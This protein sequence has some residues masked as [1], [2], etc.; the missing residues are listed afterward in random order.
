M[1]KIFL[2]TLLILIP[3]LILAAGL[4]PC[5]GPGEEACQLCHFFVMFD[6]IVDFLLFKIVPPLAILM[7]VIGGVMFMFAQFGGGEMLPGG[8]KG[9]PALLSQAK[10]LVTSVFIALVIIYGA[11]VIINTF[12][13]AIGVADWTGLKEGWWK[14]DCPIK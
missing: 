9:G 5:G 1:K 14:I 12:F 11:W 7:I 10:R 6:R 4:V 8:A 2:I 13:M 3:N